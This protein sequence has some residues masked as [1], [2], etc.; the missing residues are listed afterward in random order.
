VTN[1]IHSKS[2]SK[3]QRFADAFRL[4]KDG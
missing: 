1:L 4:R 3:I 2:V